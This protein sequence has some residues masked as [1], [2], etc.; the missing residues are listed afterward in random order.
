MTPGSA[1][2]MVYGPCP[3][4]GNWQLEVPPGTAGQVVEDAIAEHDAS[5]HPGELPAMA[6][7]QREL[8]Q[9]FVDRIQEIRTPGG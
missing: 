7:R 9:R 5:D 2:G 8:T 6:E 1:A 4:C 3:V